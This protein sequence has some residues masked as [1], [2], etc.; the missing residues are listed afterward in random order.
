MGILAWYFVSIF[1]CN[2]WTSTKWNLDL[3]LENAND[4]K[5][6]VYVRMLK[7]CEDVSSNDKDCKVMTLLGGDMGILNGKCSKN[8]TLLYPNMVSMKLLDLLS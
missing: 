1:G 5:F 3:T 2:I 8:I 7:C 6:R 4:E